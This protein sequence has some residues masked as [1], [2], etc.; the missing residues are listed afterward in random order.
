M[1]PARVP[2]FATLSMEA[3]DN[4]LEHLDTCMICR[5]A[6][7]MLCSTGRALLAESRGERDK[8]LKAIRKAA[9]ASP[10]KGRGSR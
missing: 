8:A 3:Q 6:Y 7:N 5:G 4:A 2:D 10:T 1:T 9:K